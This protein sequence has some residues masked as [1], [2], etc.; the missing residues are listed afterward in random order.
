[1]QR[2]SGQAAD[3]SWVPGNI[4]AD[5]GN[6]TTL[7]RTAFASSLKLKRPLQV[8]TVDGDGDFI[9]RYQSQRVQFLLRGNPVKSLQSKRQRLNW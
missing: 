6:D 4:F 5:K 3:G 1:M 7:M 2:L 9:N 8:L